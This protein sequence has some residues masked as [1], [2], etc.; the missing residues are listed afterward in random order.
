MGLAQQEFFARLKFMAANLHVH[1]G[2]F[3]RFGAPRTYFFGAIHASP[4]PII[5]ALYAKP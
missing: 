2:G 4:Q 3:D 5:F 1:R